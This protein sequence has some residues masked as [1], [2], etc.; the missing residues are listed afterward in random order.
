MLFFALANLALALVYYVF[1]WK[2]IAPTGYGFLVGIALAFLFSNADKIM[3]SKAWT[4]FMI[5]TVLVEALMY[6]GYWK[7]AEFTG[8]ILVVATPVLGASVFA[9]VLVITFNGATRDDKNFFVGL[10]ALCATAMNSLPL[11]SYLT[12]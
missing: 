4:L 11:I 12:K 10:L 9:G 2:D 1:E 3:R 7:N 8:L 6:Y 5:G